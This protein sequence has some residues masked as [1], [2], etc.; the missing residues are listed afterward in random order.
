MLDTYKT[1]IFQIFNVIRE[2]Q[3]HR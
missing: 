1:N 2:H 3:I